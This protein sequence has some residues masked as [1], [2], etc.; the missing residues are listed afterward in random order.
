LLFV[1][2]SSLSVAF[3][4]QLYDHL[5]RR[6]FDISVIS[7]AGAELDS[8]R[9]EGASVYAIQMQ[10]E[11]SLFDDLVSLWQL[12]RVIRKIR[13][14]IVN[15]G[16]PKAGLLGGLAALMAGVPR[17]IYT[18]HGLRLETTQGWSRKLLTF[19]ERVSCFCAHQVRCVSPSLRKRVID[20]RLVKPGKARVV[21]PG[22]CR[23]VDTEKYR[24]NDE[25]RRDGSILRRKLGIS[26]GALVVGF[27]GRFTR[28]KGIVELYEAFTQLRTTYSNLRLL[29]VGDFEEGDPVSPKIRARIE[30]DVAVIRPG[31]VTDVASYLWTMDVLALPTY[32]EGFPGVVLEAQAASVPVVTT[33]ATGAIDSLVDGVTGI[34]TEVGHVGA[35]AAALDRLLADPELR[36]R[37]GRAGC[38]W[39]QQ[40]FQ[41]EVV[42]KFLLADYLSLSEHAVC[43]HRSG[44]SALVKRGFDWLAAAILLIMSAPM[45]LVAAIAIR[46]SL[47][48]P[49][50]FQQVRPGYRGTPFTLFK[51]RTMR[52]ARKTDGSMLPDADRITRIG[53]LL[54]SMSIDE[55]PQL[56]NVLRGDMSLVGPRPLLMEYLPR[57]T[58][59]QLRRH[60]VLP[61]ITGWAQI[62]GRNVISW[63]QKFSMDT[64]YIDHWSLWL[65]MKILCGTVLRVL[66]REGISNQNC[67]TMPE[68]MG[69]GNASDIRN[70]QR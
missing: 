25:T 28:D 55:L 46:W 27:I 41:R 9:R 70:E 57:Y 18:L 32:R 21:G 48:T 58:P 45:L 64:W 66:R 5:Q 15:V 31:Y 6:G 44:L 23:G 26:E 11:I 38:A 36:T 8:A 47:G 54:R 2:T 60:E 69:L 24:A 52:D 30:S 51:F 65:D 19:T 61:G 33:D 62:N 16:T 43:G 50:L 1:F 68:F 13:P 7:S 53:S 14:D 34:H 63:E 67:A 20:L 17:R 37:M 59:E 42:W 49:V 39:V 29:M 35:L 12:W 3:Y 56:V 40:N 22:T 4:S 10:R